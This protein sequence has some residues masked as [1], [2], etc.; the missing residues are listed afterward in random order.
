MRENRSD[1]R[2]ALEEL[3]K[4]KPVLIYDGDGREEETD[5]VYAGEMVTYESVRT[6]RKDGGGLIC[7][8]VHPKASDYLGLPF[9]TDVLASAREKFEIFKNL[10]TEGIPYDEKSAFSITINHKRTFTGISD[11]DRALTIREFSK[12]AGAVFKAGSTKMK[13]GYI[14][15]LGKFFRTPGHVILLRAAEGLLFSRQGHTELSAALVEMSG[16]TPAAAIC[17][18]LGDNGASLPKEEAV[19]YAE[20]NKLVFLEGKE[21][22]EAYTDGTGCAG[23]K[24]KRKLEES[25]APVSP[26]RGGRAYP[27]ALHRR[28]EGA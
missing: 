27:D 19:K 5:M 12:L 9:M 25:S 10:R 16:L 7:V 13:N 24:E 4:G 8:A 2:K 26:G 6:M 17:E 15:K 28:R 3:R 23:K 22:V 14:E 21:L 20:R 11:S 18:M 1:I